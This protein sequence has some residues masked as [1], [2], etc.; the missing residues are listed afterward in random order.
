MRLDLSL[1]ALLDAAGG[2]AFGLVGI[3]ALVFSGPWRERVAL[4]AC[5][6]GFGGMLVILNVWPIG[7]PTA[8]VPVFVCAALALGG[9]LSL[10]TRILAPIATSQRVAVYSILAVWLGLVAL[11]A[12][13]HHREIALAFGASGDP[14]RAGYAMSAL[15]G[16]TAILAA[17][18]CAAGLRARQ[19]DDIHA[20]TW[21]ALGLSA[22]TYVLF[23]GA[24]LA[25]FGSALPP[26]SIVTGLLGV[27]LALPWLLARPRVFLVMLALAFAGLVVG[28]AGKTSG[29]NANVTF[30]LAGA[31]RVAAAYVLARALFRG[32][33]L[34]IRAPRVA[35]ERGPLVAAAL[36]VLLVVAQIAQNFLAAYYGLLMGGVVAGALLVAARPIERALEG[37]PP[38]RAPQPDAAKEDAFRAAVRLALR[39]RRITREEEIHLH[40]VAQHMGIPAGRAHELLVDVERELSVR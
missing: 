35:E 38:P 23:N 2:A 1:P 21:S 12:T 9:G 33:L 5:L 11:N 29:Q 39:D 34:G 13:L 24:R 26:T 3:L 15:A 40:R 32:D 6:T 8:T 27:A 19:A 37:R 17:I 4:G 36:A 22:A 14:L 18:L 20:R 31:V 7:D 10:V 16:T 30:G 25:A 28:L